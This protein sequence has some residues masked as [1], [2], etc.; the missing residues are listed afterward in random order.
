MTFGRDINSLY[1]YIYCNYIFQHQEK[2]IQHSPLCKPSVQLFEKLCVELID[3][4]NKLEQ[5]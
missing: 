1:T 5:F 2:N 3:G 4:I